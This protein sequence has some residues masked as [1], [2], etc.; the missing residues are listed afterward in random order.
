[1]ELLCRIG[2]RVVKLIVG[3]PDTDSG[4]SAVRRFRDGA[5]NQAK[6][7]RIARH[8]FEGHERRRSFERLRGALAP[9]SQSETYEALAHLGCRPPLKL[10]R[11]L[12]PGASGAG[13][14]SRGQKFTSPAAGFSGEQHL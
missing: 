13:S 14:G 9:A 1:V 2:A 5:G 6:V 12:G 3:D 10:V 11:H 4:W 7:A 8:I